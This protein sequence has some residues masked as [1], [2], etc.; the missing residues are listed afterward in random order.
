MIIQRTG[1]VP[2]QIEGVTSNVIFHITRP[3]PATD[4]GFFANA[5]LAFMRR[6]N[7]G[8]LYLTPLDWQIKL[9][10]AAGGGAAPEPFIMRDSGYDASF[11]FYTP[12]CNPYNISCDTQHTYD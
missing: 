12:Y 8:A 6:S 7:W 9:C 1:I 10:F 5:S 3:A 2:N 11:H 4:P